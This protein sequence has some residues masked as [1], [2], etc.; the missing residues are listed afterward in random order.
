MDVKNL[1]KQELAKLKKEID[2]REA[3]I[4]EFYNKSLIEK[5][6]KLIPLSQKASFREEVSTEI[7]FKITAVV[8]W[9]DDWYPTLWYNINNINFMNNESDY[10]GDERDGNSEINFINLIDGD[11]KKKVDKLFQS[12][13]YIMEELSTKLKKLLPECDRT[14]DDK[15]WDLL[16]K[17]Q[18]LENE[19]AK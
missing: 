11:F 16:Y 1:N 5:L 6:K 3:E 2:Q 9:E 19:K 7:T 17:V 12:K 8:E 4:S 13:K 14:D 18:E 15:I 10:Y